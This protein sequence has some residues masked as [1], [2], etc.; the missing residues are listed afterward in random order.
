MNIDVK[1][2]SKTSKLDSVLNKELDGEHH[3]PTWFYEADLKTN[4]CNLT[5]EGEV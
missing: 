2:L 1:N 3:H 5:Y 4:E